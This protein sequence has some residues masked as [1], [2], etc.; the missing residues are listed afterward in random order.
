M[1][2]MQNQMTIKKIKFMKT[3]EQ[4]Y[5]KSPLNPIKIKGVEAS[6][7]YM[8]L[9]ITKDDKP[10][11]FHR[12]RS[13]SG[14]DSKPIDCYE[15]LKPNDEKD[16]VYIDTYSTHKKSEPPEGYKFKTKKIMPAV[17]NRHMVIETTGVN[18]KLRKFP[19]E[20]F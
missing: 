18:Y 13:T 2:N 1:L 4:K 20:L 15:I 14:N 5:G 16:Y 8:N 12:I 19:D 7:E 9:L 10:F 3:E 17:I 11:L 6:I